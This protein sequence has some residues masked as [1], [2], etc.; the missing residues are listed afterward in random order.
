MLTQ[1][2]LFKLVEYSADTGIFKWKVSSRRVGAG[3]V[4]GYLDRGRY[5][6]ICIESQT[7][8]A[9]RLAWLYVYGQ[10]PSG[11]IDHING[12]KSDNRIANLRDVPQEIN[13]QNLRTA[14]K[15]NKSSRLLGVSWHKGDKAWHARIRNKNG[16][17]FLGSFEDKFAAHDAYLAAKRRLHAGC[18]I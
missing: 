18:T 12:R 4:A 5:T 13:N 1:D 2:D 8:P 17:I 9:H 16:R 11:P 14:P 3:N 10:W 6:R 15:S 7:Y